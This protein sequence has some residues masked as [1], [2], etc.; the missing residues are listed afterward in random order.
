VGLIEHQDTVGSQQQI[1]LQ[2]TQQNP[3]RHEFD[4]SPRP[5]AAVIPHLQH[6][7]QF[8][9]ASA[10]QFA[11]HNPIRTEIHCSVWPHSLI[12]PT[13]SLLVHAPE[14]QNTLSLRLRKRP[15]ASLLSIT[16]KS[17]H[18]VA[19]SASHAAANLLC[20]SPGSC[21]G[22]H[23]ARLRHAYLACSLRELLVPIA[24]LIQKLRH[25]C[26]A[27]NL[28]ERSLLLLRM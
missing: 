12:I 19:N 17:A 16:C 21:Y 6:M 5:H 10:L 27:R 11:Q 24:C 4:C 28:S 22:S 23:S 3:I 13:C 2:L 9:S 7:L 14:R 8:F 18:L 1:A 20:N 26:S 15:G 25:L